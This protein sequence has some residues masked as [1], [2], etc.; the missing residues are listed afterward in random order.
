MQGNERLDGTWTI[1]EIIRR[2]PD[3][4]GI[5][6][7]VGIDACCGGTLPLGEVTRR[8]GLDTEALLEELR[9]AAAA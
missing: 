2:H 7:R 6:K 1:N 8:H 9:S 5:F 4:V 3:T